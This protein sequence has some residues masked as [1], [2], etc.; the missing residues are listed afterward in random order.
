MEF[1]TPPPVRREK[2]YRKPVPVYIPSPPASPNAPSTSLLPL[3]P[4]VVYSSQRESI[5][6]L[7]ADWKTMLQRAMYLDMETETTPPLELKTQDEAGERLNDPP[8]GGVPVPQRP[9]SPR[10]RLPQAFRPPTPP[11]SRK[12]KFRDEDALS[13]LVAQPSSSETNATDTALRRFPAKLEPLRYMPA[14]PTQ[15][16]LSAR[17]SFRTERSAVSSLTL[18]TPGSHGCGTVRSAQ[19]H[20]SDD[21]TLDQ[22]HDLPVLPMHV[23]K[24]PSGKVEIGKHLTSA[25]SETTWRG[26]IDCLTS[27]VK[28]GFLAFTGALKHALCGCF[29]GLS[30]NVI[31]VFLPK[32]TN[33]RTT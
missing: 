28:N 32:S 8:A 24:L 17:T 1:H 22:W 9:R 13:I 23:V 30:C 25:A 11:L 33:G 2:S 26:R 21:P 20:D 10:R 16:S 14:N 12:R 6:P 19:R 4:M 31:T 7:P 5:P 18:V 15:P 27:L 3:S 29:A